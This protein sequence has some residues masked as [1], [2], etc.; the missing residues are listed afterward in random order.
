MITR[1]VRRGFLCKLLNQRQ[2]R[3]IRHLVRHPR[4][5]PES[6]VICF[7]RIP[8]DFQRKIYVPVSPCEPWSCNPDNRVV[9][10]YELNRLPDYAWVRIEVPLPELVRQYRHGFRILPV[11]CVGRDKLST[12]RRA[13]T[14][15]FERI[16]SQV[17]TLHI[18]RQ[19]VTGYGQAPVIFRESV[20]DDRRF[21]NLLPLPSRQPKPPLLVRAV[22]QP[23]VRH[24]VRRGIGI[25][26]HQDRVDDAEY[27]RRR[28]D[29]K[30]EGHNSRQGKS[31]IL[32]QL[33][34][35]IAEV[36][37][38]RL[39]ERRPP[40]GW[41]GICTLCAKCERRQLTSF[42]EETV[43]AEPFVSSVCSASCPPTDRRPRKLFDSKE[44]WDVCKLSAR[45]RPNRAAADL[46]WITVRRW[47]C[48]ES[49]CVTPTNLAA[50]GNIDIYEWFGS[51]HGAHR[52][53]ADI[54]QMLIPRNQHTSPGLTVLD[55]DSVIRGALIETGKLCVKGV[56]PL[57]LFREQK[58]PSA[59]LAQAA[60]IEGRPQDR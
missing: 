57:Q 16:R 5:Q 24:P 40:K 42:S 15:E 51:H 48:I 47:Q 54:C 27:R 23:H 58:L 14:H 28:S 13:H 19:I 21:T 53:Y 46:S 22:P 45:S 11:D 10:S 32:E 39:H 50:G 18:F 56:T 1:E 41:E 6:N 31:G 36:L 34:Q 26:V 33:S 55:P 12:E 4:L 49:V 52:P 44:S 9:L 38:Q 17:H 2:Q 20:F 35:G 8:R 59:N 3:A 60:H 43:C 25:W 37:K 30:R 29:A 7:H